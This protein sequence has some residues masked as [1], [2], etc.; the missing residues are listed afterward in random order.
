MLLKT[1]K[2]FGS[3]EELVR[4]VFLAEPVVR[5]YLTSPGFCQ[6]CFILCY[7]YSISTGMVWADLAA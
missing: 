4:Q 7:N 2:R 1:T 5:Y 3:K 6:C